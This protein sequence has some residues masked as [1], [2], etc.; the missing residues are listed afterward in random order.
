LAILVLSVVVVGAVPTT[1]TALLLPRVQLFLVQRE[2]EEEDLLKM[3]EIITG[4]SS[5]MV[6]WRRRRI[7]YC[8]IRRYRRSF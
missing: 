2:E 4:R 6:K 1:H 8:R 3:S 7:F 5:L